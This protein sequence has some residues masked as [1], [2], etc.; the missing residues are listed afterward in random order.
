MKILITGG[1]GF[2]GSHLV[3]AFQDKAEIVVL[4]N[5]RTGCRKNLS[6]LK[7]EIV[8]GS[9]LDRNLLDQILPGTDFIFHLAALVSIPESMSKPFETVEINIQG[10]LNVLEAGKKHG[11]KKLCFAS[12][13]AVYGENPEQ[14][15]VETMQPDPRTPY[16]ITKLDGEYYCAL[17]AREGWLET[18]A[19][20]FFNVF[21]PRQDP[22]GAYA[23]AVPI[24]IQKA[25][26]NEPITIFGDG[27]QT[28]DFIYVKDIVSALD[29]LAQSPGITGVYNAGYGECMSIK[30]LLRTI[31]T[32]SGSSSPIH[33]LPT[34]AGDI[35]H[36][37]ACPKKLMQAGWLPVYGVMNGLKATIESFN[38][39]L[40]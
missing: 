4:D 12:S 32:E 15:K 27:D 21:G 29:F 31:L 14:P 18:A 33:Y 25:L 11:V 37:Q 35:I 13:A 23:A 6:G 40:S 17:Y 1:A 34:R 30:E 20:R 3:E 8:E 5:F 24:F 36:S 28:R 7:C 22:S 39:R 16:G 38:N 19:L 26:L 2:I 9:I 10:L